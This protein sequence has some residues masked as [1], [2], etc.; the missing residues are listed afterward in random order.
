MTLNIDRQFEQMSAKWFY[1]HLHS[2]SLTALLLSLLHYYFSRVTHLRHTVTLSA[3][4]VLKAHYL[5]D[6]F[7]PEVPLKAYYLADVFYPEVPLKAYYL[8]D[9]FY[10]EAPLKAFYLADVFYPEAP[11]KA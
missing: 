1:P 2:T 7:Y 4:I 9:V 5:A 10:P 6:V 3:Y 8:A 11:L